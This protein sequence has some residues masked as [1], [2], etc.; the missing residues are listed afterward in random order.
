MTGAHGIFFAG[1]GDGFCRGNRI[2]ECVISKCASFGIYIA[3]DA[4]GGT[5]GNVVE[6]CTV[7][8]TTVEGIV[9]FNVASRGKVVSNHV[10]SVADHSSGATGKGI[11]VDSAALNLVIHNSVADMTL[12]FSLSAT[13]TNGPIVVSA[14]TLSDSGSPNHPWA[15]FAR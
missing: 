14:G 7:S 8:N 6:R 11:T 5:E 1:G 15:N 10:T 13:G 3:G 12:P 2:A 4:N 9:V